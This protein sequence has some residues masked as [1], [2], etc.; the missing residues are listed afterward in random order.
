MCTSTR[1]V[2]AQMGQSSLCA[3]ASIP[4]LYLAWHISAGPQSAP[5]YVQW[6]TL[7]SSPCKLS[8]SLRWAVRT[9]MVSE[10]DTEFNFFMAITSCKSQVGGVMRIKLGMT[11][12]PSTPSHPFRKAGRH[13]MGVVCQLTPFQFS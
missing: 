13:S 6:L 12:S 8:C 11:L 4:G 1:C 10:S 5:V 9:G 7:Y 3:S 2:P